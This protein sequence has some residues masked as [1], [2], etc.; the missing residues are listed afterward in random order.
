VKRQQETAF[1]QGFFAIFGE[2]GGF[3]VAGM[4]RPRD[5]S[6]FPAFDAGR[7]MVSA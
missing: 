3:A 4:G 1:F 5:A 7:D 6:S 2:S